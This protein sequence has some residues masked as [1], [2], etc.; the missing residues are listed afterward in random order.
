MLNIMATRT[1]CAIVGITVCFFLVCNAN[2]MITDSTP[3]RNHSAT[4]VNTENSIVSTSTHSAETTLSTDSDVTN[5]SFSSTST[6]T[7]NAS[8]LPQISAFTSAATT[9]STVNVSGPSTL[10]NTAT[11]SLSSSSTMTLPGPSSSTNNQTYS[12]ST[13]GET[14][15]VSTLLPTETKPTPQGNGTET[16]PNGTASTALSGAEKH[17][18][19]YSEI[20]L[21]S[22]FSVILVVVVLVILS[23]G[24][25][26]CLRGTSQYSHHPLYETSYEPDG[27]SPPDDTLVIS[28]GL[29]DAPRIYNP[30]MTV[31]DEEESQNDY[32]SI[33]S[34][35]GQF[36]LEFLPGDKD[37]DP[38]SQRRNV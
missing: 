37:I 33:N 9:Q 15:V 2:A 35:P 27:Y 30:N 29:Y 31:L 19:D 14:R 20:I 3:T 6:T 8:K 4:L 10:K 32:A 1:M 18:M 23:F 12:T 7:L 34:R 16:S 13:S 5:T 36:R 28:G 21:T 38:M 22:I 11:S 17:S 24:F 26:R 25:K